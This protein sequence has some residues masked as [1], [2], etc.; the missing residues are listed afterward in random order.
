MEEN[1]RLRKTRDLK[2]LGNIKEIFH[3]KMGTIKDINGKDP[4]E[5]EEIKKRWQE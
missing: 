3:P 1:S 2:K 5:A 4:L